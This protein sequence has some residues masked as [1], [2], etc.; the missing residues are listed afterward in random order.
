MGFG[1]TWK[2][3]MMAINPVG[4][5]PTRLVRVHL[6]ST[7]IARWQLILH[8]ILRHHAWHRAC[9]GCAWPGMRFVGTPCPPPPP[10]Q[11]NPSPPLFPP[12]PPPPPTVR[13]DAFLDALTTAFASREPLWREGPPA[14]KGYRMYVHKERV[15]VGGGAWGRGRGAEQGFGKEGGEGRVGGVGPFATT[16]CR[17]CVH[18]EGVQVGGGAGGGLE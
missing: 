13:L 3:M 2:L 7:L 10:P 9:Q 12:L 8:E 11:R 6:V 17:M 18:N 5:A 4:L 16:G 1:G 15:Q 14:S